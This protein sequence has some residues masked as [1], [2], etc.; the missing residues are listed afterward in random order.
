MD[1]SPSII[2]PPRLLLCFSPFFPLHPFRQGFYVNSDSFFMSLEYCHCRCTLW[3]KASSFFWHI[4]ISHI[5][6]PYVQSLPL[7]FWYQQLGFFVHRSG[8]EMS[9]LQVMDETQAWWLDKKIGKL[10]RSFPSCCSYG[11]STHRS[12]AAIAAEC[13]FFPFFSSLPP[14]LA[15][16]PK[17]GF[18][19]VY[20]GLAPNSQSFVPWPPHCCDYRLWRLA[21]IGCWVC[22]LSTASSV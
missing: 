11:T 15:F 13:L 4:H 17:T 19:F 10:N 1:A 6:Y 5:P 2:P 21:F 16:L 20:P 14:L 18:V 9:S 12:R 22:S 3:C 8:M 7:T